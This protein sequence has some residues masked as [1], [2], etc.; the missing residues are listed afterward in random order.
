MKRIISIILIALL[1]P[2]PVAE[3]KSCGT[4]WVTHTSKI[5]GKT[6]MRHVYKCSR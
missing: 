5:T 3:A 4:S 2:I 1:L 6:T